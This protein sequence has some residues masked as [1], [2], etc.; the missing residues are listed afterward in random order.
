M[1][2]E[3]IEEQMKELIQ[4]T[5]AA[6]VARLMVNARSNTETG[7]LNSH[8]YESKQ[9][10]VSQDADKEYCSSLTKQ[11]NKFGLGKDTYAMAFKA[12]HW[13]S[14]HQLKLS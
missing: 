14:A 10:K 13:D 9:L 12:L 1:R 7:Q 6:G 8:R 3:Q 11:A 5:M 4:D 2:R